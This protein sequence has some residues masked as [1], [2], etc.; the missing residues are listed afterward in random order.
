MRSLRHWSPKF[1]KDRLAEMYSHKSSPDHPWLT[2]D[3]NRILASFLR[4]TDVGLEL[5]SGRSTL[6]FAKQ[7]K[8]VTS[9]EHDRLWYEKVRKMLNAS[10]LRNVDYHLI[11]DDLPEQGGAGAS[12]VRFI[13]TLKTAEFDYALIDG[14]YRDF[15][16]LA[17][18]RLLRPGG[19]LI[20]DNVNWYLPH[21]TSTPY[22]RT[23][24][25]GP[26]S[27]EWE[28]FARAVSQ[29]RSIWTSS[30][31]TDTALFFKPCS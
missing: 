12:Y 11:P 22:S 24:H 14:I 23:S 7:T 27:P 28:E 2:R 20:V 4:D 19:V 8:H 16:A 31:V 21:K 3:A 30:G 10:A 15:C 18:M 17:S 26:E 6:W 1:I 25:Q 5:G 29:W 9:V 13:G